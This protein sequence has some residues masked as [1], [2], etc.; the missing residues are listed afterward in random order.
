MAKTTTSRAPTASIVHLCVKRKSPSAV[1]SGLGRPSAPGHLCARS[2][3]FVRSLWRIGAARRP[4]CRD[5]LMRPALIVEQP[6]LKLLHHP[7]AIKST[8]GFS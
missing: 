3:A 5:V 2:G 6:L 4:H 8:K 7:G 1:A